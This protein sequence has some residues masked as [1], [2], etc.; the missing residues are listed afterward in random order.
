MGS[1]LKLHLGAE[2]Q[3]AI[4]GKEISP[5]DESRVRAYADDADLNRDRELSASEWTSFRSR[6]TSPPKI[7]SFFDKRLSGDTILELKAEPKRNDADQA[8]YLALHAAEEKNKL[9]IL[10]EELKDTGSLSPQEIRRRLDA[11][12]SLALEY[13]RLGGTPL[14]DP[15]EAASVR[16]T[17]NGLA[18]AVYEQLAKW[19]DGGSYDEIR[20]LAPLYDA[21]RF[22]SEGDVESAQNT[23]EGVCGAGEAAPPEARRLLSAIRADQAE[24]NSLIALDI[25]QGYAEELSAQADRHANETID[26]QI[27]QAL[28]LA[29]GKSS[30]LDLRA[31]ELRKERLLI[32]ELRKKILNREAATLREALQLTARSDRADHRTLALQYLSP[33]PE[34]SRMAGE[35]RPLIVEYASQTTPDA[36]LEERLFRQTFQSAQDNRTLKS[37]HAV[38]TWLEG[39]TPDAKRRDQ[40]KAQRERIQEVGEDYASTDIG[41]AFHGVAEMALAGAVAAPVHL[42][43]LFRLQKMG[44]TG[45]RGVTL[46]LGAEAATEGAALGSIEVGKSAFSLHAAQALSPDVIAKTYGANLLM[47]GVLKPFAR[48]GQIAG[49]RAARSLDLI[50]K[51]GKGLSAGGRALSWSLGHGGGFAGMVAANRGNQAVGF[52]ES[53]GGSLSHSLAEDFLGYVRFAAAHRMLDG[54]SRGKLSGLSRETK[55]RAAGVENLLLAEAQVKH[56]GYRV[57]HRSHEGETAGQPTFSDPRGDFLYRQFFQLAASRP[58]FDGDKTARLI[59][60]GRRAE[61]RDYLKGFGLK[62]VYEGRTFAA[63]D[64][65]SSPD[66]PRS[67]LREVKTRFGRG[68]R[69]L[70]SGP[71]LLLMGAGVGGPGGG[72]PKPVPS[73]QPT[74]TWL[75][76]LLGRNSKTVGKTLH[77]LDAIERGHPLAKEAILKSLMK[78]GHKPPSPVKK[79]IIATLVASVMAGNKHALKILEEATGAFDFSREILRLVRARVPGAIEILLKREPSKKTTR[80]LLSLFDSG[81]YPEISF[82]EEAL[83]S[84]MNREPDIAELVK[85]YLSNANYPEDLQTLTELAEQGNPIVRRLRIGE[86]NFGPLSFQVMPQSLEVRAPW[87]EA[88]FKYHLVLES[89]L[90]ASRHLLDR[91]VTLIESKDLGFDPWALPPRDSLL[92]YLQSADPA[93]ALPEIYHHRSFTF[94]PFAS[95]PRKAMPF[96]QQMGTEAFAAKEFSTS[97]GFSEK[98]E[99]NYRI[100]KANSVEY[101]NI[102]TKELLEKDAG[103]FPDFAVHLELA[104]REALKAWRYMSREQ[105]VTK[106]NEHQADL[107][108]R[109]G[110]F[111]AQSEGYAE[112]KL[113]RHLFKIRMQMETLESLLRANPDQHPLTSKQWDAEAHQEYLKM[114]QQ[115]QWPEKLLA[116]LRFEK[117]WPAEIQG[118]KYD[119]E[120]GVSIG[121]LDASLLRSLAL[122]TALRDG[123]HGGPL[124]AVRALKLSKNYPFPEIQ[125]DMIRGVIWYLRENLSNVRHDNPEVRKQALEALRH[126]LILTEGSLVSQEF[127]RQF[128]QPG[129]DFEDRENL[130]ITWSRRQQPASAKPADLPRGFGASLLHRAHRLNGLKGPSFVDLWTLDGTKPLAYMERV[131]AEEKHYL[132][133]LALEARHDP[134]ARDAMK[135]FAE[136]GYSLAGEALAFTDMPFPFGPPILATAGGKTGELVPFKAEQPLMMESKKIIPEA[137][138]KQ[139]FQETVAEIEK[140][141]ESLPEELQDR[142]LPFSNSLEAAYR[143]SRQDSFAHG[144]LSNEE[145]ENRLVKLND[146][147]PDPAQIAFYLEKARREALEEAR[148]LSPSELQEEIQECREILVRMRALL[149][150][151]GQGELSFFEQVV[152]FETRIRL[153]IFKN[154]SRTPSPTRD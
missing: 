107:A 75:D 65:D 76:S 118:E 88:G 130:L 109:L 135:R 87:L 18:A 95:L 126:F 68:L 60:R 139:I 111:S 36:G 92:F 42:A 41:D 67:T 27:V 64:R 94:S 40:V 48:A 96:R 121:K 56:L 11:F 55:V 117:S 47:M 154:F 54:F 91:E 22:L 2:L 37:A 49:P 101:K 86:S 59:A 133:A 9:K 61:L 143:L 122:L 140:A 151:S 24:H 77:W 114:L 25:W 145:L 124:A 53:P 38:Y 1:P 72:R 78:N 120:K 113:R 132:E 23:L 131:P 28:E 43:A 62:S 153:E 26:G 70:L 8:R 134:A 16:K 50:A 63:F 103:I 102:G 127:I 119:P 83:R 104:Q 147:E 137:L 66:K 100:S 71:A 149:D 80:E 128:E 93:D 33:G 7:A 82:A 148:E 79:L 51:G 129:F 21:Y 116:A 150:P 14:E 29:T 46:A 112:F 152:M 17:L 35:I 105:I 32:A 52:S 146:P 20:K 81:S 6:F 15:K 144:K 30:G 73:F 19:A 110:E 39:K 99:S 90:V 141:L 4:A 123:R 31:Q 3:T 69:Q 125:E 85:G 10:A 57:T 142:P 138:A 84:R 58:G 12:Q 13:L 97:F 108:L 44:V 106:I 115:T 34:K 136:W 89:D 74:S 98:L 45:W 5:E